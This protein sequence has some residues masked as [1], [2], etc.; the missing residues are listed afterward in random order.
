MLVVEAVD[1]KLRLH[2][3]NEEGSRYLING[4]ELLQLPLISVLILRGPKD[5]AVRAPASIAQS[6]PLASTV[7]TD[8]PNER[9]LPC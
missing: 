6:R 2:C 9:L 5:S 3:L 8:Y 4:R 1:N 7:L